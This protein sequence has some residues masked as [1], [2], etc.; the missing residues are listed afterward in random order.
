MEQHPFL[1]SLPAIIALLFKGAIYLFAHYSETHNRNT[2]VFLIFLFAL[3]IQNVAEVSHFFVIAN[4]EIPIF[5]FQVYYLSSIA[6]LALALHLG[7]LIAIKSEQR[8]IPGALLF[9]TYAFAALLV[10]MLVS[11]DSLVQGYQRIGYT[12][13]RDPGPYYLLFEIYTIGV[14]AGIAA[15]FGYG[16]LCQ[17][18]AAKRAQCSL[19]LIGI[20]PALLVVLLV[21]V[22]LHFGI[23]W[24]NATI[25][26]PFTITIFLVVS[27]YAIYQHRIFD[28]H[29]Y[30]PWSKVRRRKTVFHNNIRR[31]ITEIADLPSVNQ[32]VQRISD[33]FHCPVLLVG[34]QKPVFAGDVPHRMYELPR[35]D[36]GKIDQ[37]IFANEIAESHPDMCEKLRAH[38]ISAVIPFY[39]YSGN[40]AGWLLLGETFTEHVYSPPDFRLVEELFGK[41]ADLFVEKFA[42]LRSQLRT[43]NK[44]IHNLRVDYAKIE[45]QLRTLERE[46]IALR[47]ANES[48]AL[49][50]SDISIART[51]EAIG[52]TLAIPMVFLGRDKQMT[53]QLH[54][55]FRDV[56]T[57]VSPSTAAFDRSERSGALICRISGRWSKL[58]QYLAIRT[59]PLVCVLYG[60]DARRFVRHGLSR[61]GGHLIDVLPEP[62]PPKT[63]VSRVRTL[64]NLRKH[65]FSLRDNRHPLIG[66]SAAFTSYMQRLQ[67]A[68]GFSDPVLIFHDDAGLLEESAQYLHQYGNQ[69]AKFVVLESNQVD[70]ANDLINTT[71]L[72][73]EPGEIS[74]GQAH[75]LFMEFSSLPALKRS[76]IIFG[77][78]CDEAKSVR[79]DR[80]HNRGFSLSA[81]RLSARQHDIPLLAQYFTLRFNLEF[82]A[83]VHLTAEEIKSLQLHEPAPWTVEGLRH[84][85]AAFLNDKAHTL[86]RDKMVPVD[87]IDIVSDERSLDELIAE[88]ESRIIRLALERCDWNKA[89]AARLLG[90]RSN[91]LYYKI[92]RY[93]LEYSR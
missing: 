41:M 12:L 37:I 9:G 21:V 65:I 79:L 19:L 13:T 71:V 30:L 43:A 2:Q 82:G 42:T 39:P 87:D 48:L 86:E 27:A 92:Q 66:R 44:E 29:L 69:H 64:L 59:D 32:I 1:N 63:A 22:L 35:L 73:Q 77:C 20:S 91:T 57:F 90:V 74:L 53:Q 7:V 54:K 88:F 28:I 45:K 50:V 62:A 16:A 34:A 18:S 26:L 68:A 75:R 70:D 76:R 67:F 10:V 46:N 36:L 81:P 58:E 89:K 23:K 52:T 11:G 93:G 49:T 14:A 8:V 33:L 55:T 47:G 78:R 56:R 24:V 72:I 38:G 15:L 31:L 5:E 60:P 80:G 3:S 83:W 17:P 40:M 25:I 4:D 61:L 6:G 85:V 51:T 84:A